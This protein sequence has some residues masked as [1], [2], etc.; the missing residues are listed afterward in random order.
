MWISC[1]TLY[2][3]NF[4]F[5]VSTG[6]GY[7][8]TVNAVAFLGVT[9]TPTGGAEGAVNSR[10]KCVKIKFEF[11]LKEKKQLKLTNRGY[12]LDPWWWKEH[13]KYF[14]TKRRF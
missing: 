11:H 4:P 3:D 13:A 1:F 14:L 6:G 12:E 5:W 10:I 8:L 9:R 7:Q 2:P